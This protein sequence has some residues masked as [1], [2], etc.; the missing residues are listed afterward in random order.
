MYRNKS[1]RHVQLNTRANVQVRGC[2]HPH[3]RLEDT[4]TRLR[5]RGPEPETQA[6][7]ERE[8]CLKGHA[9]EEL[10]VAGDPFS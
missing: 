3:S 9:R 4:F 1:I 10:P 8:D 5:I 2:A 7:Q 6:L